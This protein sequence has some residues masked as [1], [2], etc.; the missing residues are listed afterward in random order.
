[1][2]PE[3]QDDT[4]EENREERETTSEGKNRHEK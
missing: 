3:V 4:Y 2:T 1:M